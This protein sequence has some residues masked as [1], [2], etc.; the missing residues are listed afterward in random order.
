MGSTVTTTFSLIGK[1][2]VTVSVL[3][4]GGK[5]LDT[6][7]MTANCLYIKRELRKLTEEDRENFL[8]AMYEMWRLGTIAGRE[9]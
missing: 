4:K 9:T 7:D 1:H 6:Y 5:V 2:Q 3:S 8:D